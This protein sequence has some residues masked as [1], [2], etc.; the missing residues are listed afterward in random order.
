M[1]VGGFQRRLGSGNFGRREKGTTRNFAAGTRA[2]RPQN[3]ALHA[4]AAAF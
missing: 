4:K 1:D 3:K 2:L